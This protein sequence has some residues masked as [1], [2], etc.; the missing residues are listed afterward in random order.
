[1]GRSAACAAVCTCTVGYMPLAGRKGHDTPFLLLHQQ[2]KQCVCLAYAEER[3]LVVSPAAVQQFELLLGQF[4]GPRERERWQ[5]LRQ[6]VHVLGSA[7]GSHPD[8]GSNADCMEQREEG[9]GVEA[10]C[11]S[12]GVGADGA[13]CQ[14]SSMTSRVAALDKVGGWGA[15]RGACMHVVLALKVLNFRACQG[16]WPRSGFRVTIHM[17]LCEVLEFKLLCRC[18][19]VCRLRTCREQCLGLAMRCRPSR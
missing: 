12:I 4:G 11:T 14:V 10:A 1:M 16:G 15:P 5:Q 2:N 18:C 3:R 7:P 19:L 13:G 9:Q 6:R 8:K 17:V